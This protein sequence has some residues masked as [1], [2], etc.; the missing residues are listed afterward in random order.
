MR[1][2]YKKQ[3]DIYGKLLAAPYLLIMSLGFDVLFFGNKL[4]VPTS[5]QKFMQEP[6]NVQLEILRELGLLEL[7]GENISFFKL[8]IIITAIGT[9]ILY[10]IGRVLGK[11]IFRSN[12]K[13]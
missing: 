10:N 8:Y 13:Y 11:K 6:I 1:Y 2:F 7:V 3:L 12:T 4:G 5:W 9:I